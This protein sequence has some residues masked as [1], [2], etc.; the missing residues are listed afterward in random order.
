VL[1]GYPGSWNRDNV[2]LFSPNAVLGARGQSA[3]VAFS[4]PTGVVTGQAYRQTASPASV[5][6]GTA[7]LSGTYGYILAGIAIQNGAGYYYSQAGSATGDGQGNL[8][9]SGMVNVNG[10]TVT[11]PGQGN[12]SVASD[13]S[14]TASVRSQYGTANY[15]TAVVLDGKG[16]LFMN[17]DAG[18]AVGGFAAPQFAAPQGA[19]VNA[20]SFDSSALAPGTIFS[21]F[22]SGLPQSVASAQV[23]V[24][25][26]SA[27]VFFANGSQV[28]AQIPYEVPT[29]RPVV[30][31]VT[32]AGKASNAVQLTV[33]PAGPGIFTSSGNRAIV[34]N[35][36][37]SV[38]S[39]TNPA[40]VGDTVIVY[41]TGAG[42]VT[43]PVATYLRSTMRKM[44][45]IVDTSARLPSNVS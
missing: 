21:V 36:D 35:Q 18:Y 43:P 10:A 19:V 4:M 24:S 15:F 22:G 1:N 5:Q 26:Q 12:Y 23:L 25:G 27:P 33:H 11:V 37:Y 29:D 30:L 34:Q 3:F 28:N 16:L 40:H 17:S 9:V 6:C 44:V 2:I 45:S 20:A 13:C 42:G 7:S 39:P 31:S 38:N 32:N 14:G 41:L 8:T